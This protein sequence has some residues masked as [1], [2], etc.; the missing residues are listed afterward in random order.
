[1]S[2]RLT[3]PVLR[4]R[5][6]EW[7]NLKN[8]L[9]PRAK[10]RIRLLKEK[11]RAL[12][13]EKEWLETELTKAQEE[14]RQKQENL[15][16]LR[17]LLFE[18]QQPRHRTHRTRKKKRRGKHSYRRQPPDH[19]DERKTVSPTECTT[20]HGPLSDAQ[21]SRVRLIEDIVLNPKTI[22]TEWT[23][24]R[25]WCTVCKKL[26]EAAVP[27]VVPH[28]QLGL[29]TLTMVILY[30]YQF[31][32][33]YGKIRDLLKVSYGLSISEGEIAHLLSEARKLV[34][35]KWALIE[36][37]VRQ[38]KRV[39]CDETG[40]YI[41]GEKVWAHVFSSDDA[42]LYVIHDTR[43]KGVAE[44]ALGTDFEGIRIT[45]CLPNYKNLAGDH[46]I[47]WAHL[48]REAGENREREKD[49][50]ERQK[51]AIVLDRIYAR[52]RKETDEWQE[53]RA[54]HAKRWCEKEVDQL[55]AQ[56]WNDP[57]SKKLIE[58][59]RT[60]RSAL[61]TCLT[62]PD[63]PADNNEAERCL[64]KLV[65]QRKIWGGNRSAP[66]AQIHAQMMSILETLRKEGRDTLE[67]LQE[68]L[69]A[70]IA[71]RLSGG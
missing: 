63:I 43:G 41:N 64:R 19:I 61:F 12:Q 54:A 8:I 14:L 33:P 26:V 66:H 55:T 48:T 22:V 50:R 57:P 24:T 7:R 27:G 65:V 20:C 40:W 47:C 38:G 16:K 32:L 4:L 3:E 58:R 46:Q 21:S 70:G 13:E 49:N 52:L 34:G 35:E 18:R 62:E 25:H 31:N 1:M 23:I 59:L 9:Y 44:K 42:T 6:I 11:N 67:G 68:L 10:E 51:V 2:L 29:N 45:D 17:K 28:A 56:Q 5:L 37:A 30:R 36:E 71:Q 15:E 69:S 53:E 60:F 39:H